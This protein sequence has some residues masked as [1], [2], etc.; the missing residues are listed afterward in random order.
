MLELSSNLVQLGAHT[1]DKTQA[2][3]DVAAL[4]AHAGNIHPDYAEGML[5]RERTA[6]TYIGSG[7]AIPHGTPGTKHLVRHTGIAVLQVPAGVPWGDNGERAHLIVGI[8]AQG[9]EHIEVLRRLTRVLADPAQAEHLTRTTHA[10]DIITAL[11]GTAPADAP[12]PAPRDLPHALT[13]T[14]PNPMGMHARPASVLAKLAQASGTHVQIRV[15][16][17]TADASSI[18]QLLQLGARRGSELVLSTDAPGADATLTALRDAIA[19]GLGDDLNAPL[20][21][22]APTRRAPD[23][24]PR[25]PTSTL[26]GLGASGGLAIGVT[27]QHRQQ[28]L[29]V[30]EHGSDALT[31]GTHLDRALDATLRDLGAL[32]ADLRARGAADRAAIFDA[33]ATLVQDPDLL[34]D[35]TARI[36]DGASA[37]HAVYTA[38]QDRA[39]AMARLDDPTLAARAADLSDV[40]RRVVRHLLGVEPQTPMQ[41]G[42]PVVLLA[43]DLA[44]GDTATLDPQQV[45]ALCTAQGGPTSHTAIIARGLG[46]PAVVGAGDALL[47][48]PDGTPCIVDGDAGFVY[49]NPSDADLASAREH[50]AAQ[51]RA[52]QAARAARHQRATTLDGHTVEVAANINRAN[53]APAALDAGAEGVG[54]MRTEFLFLEADSAPSEDDQYAAYL[55]MSEALGEHPLIIRTLDIGGDKDVPY[56]GLQRED[57]SFLGLRGIRLCFERPDLFLPQLRAIY[58][59]ARDGG[60]NIRVM[61]PMIATP[62]EF[63]RARNIAEQV[64]TELGAPEVP[65][66]LMIEVPSAALTADELARD[67]DFFSIGTNDLTQYVLAMDRLHPVLA[68]QADALHPAVL[69][70]VDL[71]VRAARAHGRWVGV[72]GGAAGDEA[73]ALVLAGLGVHELSVSTPQVPTVKAALRTQRLADLQVLAQRAL[74]AND[75]AEVRGLVADVLN[76]AQVQ[77]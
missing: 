44:P 28:D 73:G 2:I 19:R 74:A 11:T 39:Q 56:L 72:C 32:A 53:A 66:G 51:H 15:G 57:N 8:A 5:D 24:T 30:P 71:T 77:A 37:A 12:S 9:D 6:N 31:E 36:L 20:P 38:G 25:T 49:L 3:R 45:L 35:A 18:M 47:T 4:L 54:L 70:A 10:A 75:A 65:L 63:R 27:R 1:A 14:L 7:V 21:S 52:A 68:R 40:T 62:A 26:E 55:A 16:D 67:A 22:A 69:R 64:R 50:Q 42:A 59:A 33:H 23:W 46:L 61:F 76:A 60:R 17:R 58:R 43:P 41:A 34:R 29:T 13:V 48:V